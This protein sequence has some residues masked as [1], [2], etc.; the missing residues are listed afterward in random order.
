MLWRTYKTKE[1]KRRKMNTM[2]V[3]PMFVKVCQYTCNPIYVVPVCCICL[4]TVQKARHQ[5]VVCG[6]FTHLKCIKRWKSKS[7]TK[8]CPTCRTKL[9]LKGSKWF[10]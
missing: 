7:K 4:E 1:E 3:N 9:K 10:W 5:C 6:H 8:S 2:M